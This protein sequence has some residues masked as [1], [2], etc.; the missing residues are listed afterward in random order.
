MRKSKRWPDDELI[1]FWFAEMYVVTPLLLLSL[2]FWLV[3]VKS[4]IWYLCLALAGYRLLDLAQSLASIFV[5]E[6]QRRRD[7][8]GGY[9]LVRHGL[10]WV[11]LTLLNFAEIVLYF[12][13][14]YLTWGKSFSPPIA[15][16]VGAI[17]QSL[18]TFIAGGGSQPIDDL[19]CIIVTLHLGYFVFFL[20]VIAPIALSVIRAKERT[21]EVL[22]HDVSPDKRI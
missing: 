10:R 16:R 18:A 12:S 7:E 22:G 9:I 4:T 19:G 21:S 1:P 13:F 11:L 15:T 20:V 6:P 14:V 3:P 5:F 17:Y 8:Q 2:A